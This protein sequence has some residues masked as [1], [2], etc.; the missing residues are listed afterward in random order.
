MR[1]VTESEEAV[2]SMA[3]TSQAGPS[4]AG[5]SQAG[6][7]TDGPS[8]ASPSTAGQSTKRKRCQRCLPRDV[9]TSIV[10]TKCKHPVC[11]RHSAVI[12]VMCNK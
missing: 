1:K 12:C 10:C 9:K 6:P 5:P 3:G 8:Q 4:T 7:S 11:K 2:S